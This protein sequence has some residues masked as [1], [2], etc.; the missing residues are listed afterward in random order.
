MNEDVVIK[1]TYEEALVLYGFFARF[2]DTD[3]FTMKH[4]SE[5]LA[6]MRISAQLDKSLVVIFQPDYAN[7]LSKAQQEVASGFEGVAPGVSAQ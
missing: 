3:Q 2:E 4:N 1:L 5:Y 7:K 6:F